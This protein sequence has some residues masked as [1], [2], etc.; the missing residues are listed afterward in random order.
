MDE[1]YEE[2]G[3]E[4]ADEFW[5]GQHEIREWLGVPSVLIDRVVYDDG[6]QEVRCDDPVG[7]VLEALDYLA[8][9]VDHMPDQW[10]FDEEERD[11]YH[12]DYVMSAMEY[13]PCYHLMSAD[14]WAC[15]LDYEPDEDWWYCE[16]SMGAKGHAHLRFDFVLDSTEDYWSRLAS[17]MGIPERGE[18]CGDPDCDFCTCPT[19]WC[20]V[21]DGLQGAISD[22]LED[23]SM[24]DYDGRTDEE[25]VNE[26][27]V[28]MME[29]A[30]LLMPDDLTPEQERFHQA[31][32]KG[33]I[34]DVLDAL[35]MEVRMRMLRGEPTEEDEK[36]INDTTDGVIAK[37]EA[38][39]PGDRLRLG[40]LTIRLYDENDPPPEEVERRK[41]QGRS[42]P[43]FEGLS[44]K[45][46]A[47][48]FGAQMGDE[49]RN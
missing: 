5:P 12:M 23:W 16:T 9:L 35:P 15:Y 25:L 20:D 31:Y 24:D 10:A 44:M 42:F 49:S 14:L 3:D 43:R 17:R 40:N 1:F 13:G 38:P 26:F 48:L 4:S 34:M 19:N 28:L 21:D 47:K 22:D 45:D 2:G 46:K 29:A 18:G 37:Y 6:E 30:G 11:C 41:R 32:L 27:A 39:K 36:L 8:A 7:C 33:V